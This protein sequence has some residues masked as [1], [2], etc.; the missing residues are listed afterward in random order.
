MVRPRGSSPRGR[1]KRARVFA[2]A[3]IGGLIPARAGKTR[4]RTSSTSV[5]RAHPRAGGE[6][7]AGDEKG[8]TFEGSSPRG[9]GKLRFHPHNAHPH[10]LIPAR[11]GKTPPR[12]ARRP[13]RPA[14]PRAGGE[15]SESGSKLDISYGS[16]PRGRGKLALRSGDIPDKRLIPARA[17]KTNG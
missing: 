12:S 4:T 5:S 17:G 1:G 6:N 9:R 3:A 14:H 10:G 8:A 11:A 16:S 2:S 13:S 15:N 7:E